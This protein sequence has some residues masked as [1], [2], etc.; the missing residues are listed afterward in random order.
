MLSRF[1]FRPSCLLTVTSLIWVTCAAAADRTPDLDPSPDLQSRLD[2]VAANLGLGNL[3]AA[4]KIG[5]SLIDVSDRNQPRYAGIHDHQMIY[6]ASLSKIAV[7]LAGFQKIEDGLLD[8]S[9][10]RQRTFTKMI[11]ESSNHAASTAIQNVGFQ[12]VADTLRSDRYHLYDASR[13]GGLWVGKA[14][15][16]PKDRWKRDPLYN[17][18][19][20][21]NSYQAA[22]LFW[23]LDRGELVS[24]RYSAE[25]KEILSKPA[26]RHKFVLGLADRPGRNIHRKSGTWRNWHADAALVEAG[27]KRYIAAA[28][29]NSPDGADI[30]VRLIRALD[31]LIVGSPAPRTRLAG[32]RSTAR[33]QATE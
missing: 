1:S 21:A 24:P 12:F 8:Y 11:R 6:A 10:E 26:I 7:L 22:R 17:L 2:S 16:G 29:V 18:S 4:G 14:Y 31:S 32:K 27:S 5:V 33:P 9:P 19:H 23:L 20:G 25:M 28:L 3:I 15:G 30:L 13:S